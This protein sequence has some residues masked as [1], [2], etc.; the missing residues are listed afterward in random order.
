MTNKE[1]RQEI[2][3]LLDDNSENIQEGLYIQLCNKLGLLNFDQLLIDPE[4]LNDPDLERAS[5]EAFLIYE[6]IKEIQDIRRLHQKNE[7]RRRLYVF[8]DKTGRFVLKTGRTGQRILKQQLEL[9]E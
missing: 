9:R 3:N 8:N 2:I 5:T 1:I 6:K 7:I 4:L